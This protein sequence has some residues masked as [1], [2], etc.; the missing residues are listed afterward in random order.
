[1]GTVSCC[2]I[3]GVLAEYEFGFRVELASLGYT[4]SS[5]EWKINDAS[6]LS[7]WMTARG[8]PPSGLDGDHLAAFVA[9]FAASRKTPPSR[10]R[11]EQLL[12]FLRSRG[13]G[14]PG[15]V[16]E[17]DRL[18]GLMAAYRGWMVDQRG[19]AVRTMERYERTARR[20]L[21]QC[22]S[23]DVGIGSLTARS[24]TDFLLGVVSRGLS[25]GSLR[26][27]VSEL[28]S[29]LRFLYVNGLIDAPLVQAIPPV[30]GWKGVAVP[31][32]MPAGLVQEVLDSCDRSTAAGTRDFAMLTLLARLGLRA[33]EV[34]GLTLDDLRWR[35]GEVVV[36]GKSRRT[37]R[38]PLPVDVGAAVAEYLRA[39]RPTAQTRA[40]FVTVRAPHRP[41]CPAAV[42]QTVWRQCDKAGLPGV[43]AHAL[44][45]ALA[46]NLLDRGVRLPEIGQLLRH[47]DLATTAI[48]AK[49]DYT[50]LRELAPAW[51]AAAR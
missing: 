17:P 37:D 35:D 47:V 43:R 6:R 14:A 27:N 33:C 50:A 23:A 13:A 18:D 39:A 28:R 24:V 25:T 44:R 10:G 19:L 29:V 8:L 9:E 2:R 40:V 16:A 4:P 45:H 49:V 34:A 3:R 12:R 26:A 7:R 11:F 48:Y 36:R 32:R 46:T 5:I 20:F 42:S 30:P 41:L 22:G 1:M 31:A 21:E 51:T 15:T 38:I